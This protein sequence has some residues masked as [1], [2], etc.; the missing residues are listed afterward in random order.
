[1]FKVVRLN[2]ATYPV[3]AGER[4]E[5][6]A[7]GAAFIAIEGQNP[8][9]ILSAAADCD[10]LLVIS[11]RVPAPVIDRLDRCR[12]ISRLGAGTDRIDVDAA[13]R[14]GIVVAN[15][16]D[17]CENEQ[18]EHTLT[19]LLA[20]ARRLPYMTAAMHRGDW[21]AR[22]HPG[23]HRVAGR[24]LG[25]IGFGASARGVAARARAFGL[26]LLAWARTPD[27]YQAEAEHLG[28]GLVGLDDLLTESDFVSIHLP[29]TP[30]TRH[31]LGAAKL[32]RMKPTAVLVNTARGAIVDEAALVDA[33]RTG[34]LAG[35]ALDVFEGVDVFALPGTP[36]DHPLLRLDN[37]I[38]T[39][40]CAGSSVESTLDSKVRGARNAAA[41]LRG[42]WPAAVVNP[43][44]RPR[45]PLG[46]A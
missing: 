13:T 6:E 9:E 4:A 34:R 32:A 16:P 18:A 11:A 10:A 42:R 41:V 45:F 24:T 39:P 36:A 22:G 15:V 3:E 38:L 28:A 40:H 46:K 20:F 26:R 8:D 17:F 2:A 25:L 31:L 37:V 30:E 35:A 21:T 44:V 23:V 5:L 43:G 12:V 29:L 7:A 19:L 27:K 1:M 33:L 14:R